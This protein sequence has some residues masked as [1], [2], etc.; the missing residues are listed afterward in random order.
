MTEQVQV[1]DIAK[2]PRLKALQ[3][4]LASLKELGD[5]AKA[6]QCADLILELVGKRPAPLPAVIA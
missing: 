5:H 4:R 6:S 3:S 2:L 1:V